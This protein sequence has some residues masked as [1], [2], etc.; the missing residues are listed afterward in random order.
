MND[1][2]SARP[3]VRLSI[4]ISDRL[5]VKIQKVQFLKKLSVLSV[6]KSNIKWELL[7]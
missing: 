6:G 2:M 3:P 5:H 7:M 1:C 4:Y